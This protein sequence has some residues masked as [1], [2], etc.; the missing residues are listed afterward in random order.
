[1]NFSSGNKVLQ[2]LIDQYHIYV[3]NQN[4]RRRMKPIKA[5]VNESTLKNQLQKLFTDSFPQIQ[6]SRVVSTQSCWS[7]F[8]TWI[9]SVSFLKHSTDVLTSPGCQSTLLLLPLPVCL[10]PLWCRRAALLL[11]LLRPGLVFSFTMWAYKPVCVVPS[12][13]VTSLNTFCTQAAP[14]T[15]THTS[16][17]NLD[18]IQTHL[19]SF[20]TQ[21]QRRRSSVLVFIFFVQF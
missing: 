2:I 21:R 12:I 17:P 20:L 13:N 8:H 3:L 16:L 4:P 15:H 1:M 18:R 19:F 9:F 10:G 7:V 11:S 14:N 5:T 6:S